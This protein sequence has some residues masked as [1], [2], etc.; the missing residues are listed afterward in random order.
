MFK[1]N[2]INIFRLFIECSFHTSNET[3]V[4]IF[5]N[6]KNK[7]I[8]KSKICSWFIQLMDTRKVY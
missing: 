1:L 8:Y 7:I 6:L 5:E 4:I 3:G 2:L